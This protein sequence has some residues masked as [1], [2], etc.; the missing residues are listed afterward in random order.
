MF[1][2]SGG[3]ANVGV[4]ILSETQTRSGI[5]VPAL[6]Q[7]FLEKLRRQH[8]GCQRARLA[9]KPLGGIVR[10]YG[11]AGPNHFDGGV[12]VGDAGCFVDSMTGEGITPAMESALI[13][14]S[15]L[16]DAITAGR[17]DAAQLSA[18]E[19]RFRQYFDPAFR[20]VDFCAT[21]LRNRFLRDF[22]L[23]VVARGC[24]RA[25]ED[26]EFARVAG[27]AFGGLNV[28]PVNILWHLWAKL[29]E[30]TSAGSGRILVDGLSGRGLS[31]MPWIED[32]WAF[33]EG[34]WRSVVDDPSWHAAWTADVVRTWL[35][36][37][38]T[39]NAPGDPR[40]RGPLH[41]T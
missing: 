35:L 30:E 36:V 41:Q 39:L 15:V 26:T 13:A 8:P 9:S 40:M 34:W 5:S 24:Q 29:I 32:V 18:Y 22:W 23:R 21:L 2:M 17:T 4:G 33:S 19:R 20:Y 25:R 12:L 37:A 7:A 1:P 31:S 6:F 14:S 3:R 16:A 11:C 28:Q 10:T 38:G 27:A